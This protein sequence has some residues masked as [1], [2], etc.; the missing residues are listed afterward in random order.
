[1]GGGGVE[2]SSKR[3][4]TFRS[5]STGLDHAFVVVRGL[6]QTLAE[7]SVCRDPGCRWGGGQLVS[8]ITI[9]GGEHCDL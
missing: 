3:N 6:T 8:L 5:D 7:G 4:A 2:Q 9:H 1:M